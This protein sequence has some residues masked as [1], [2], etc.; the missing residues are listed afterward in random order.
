MTPK[1]IDNFFKLFQDYT[2][3]L[4]FAKQFHFRNN[5]FNLWRFL[6]NFTNFQCSLFD[7]FFF[8]PIKLFFRFLYR[9][10]E[11]YQRNVKISHVNFGWTQ[12]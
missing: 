2:V 10:K 4:V 12:G 3:I 8:L 6:K 11:T 1:I 5:S 7:P 9:H